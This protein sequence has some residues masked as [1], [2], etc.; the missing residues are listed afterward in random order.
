MLPLADSQGDNLDVGTLGLVGLPG[1]RTAESTPL[2][3]CPDRLNVTLRELLATRSNQLHSDFI[4]QISGESNVVLFSTAEAPRAV[5]DQVAAAWAAERAPAGDDARA[6]IALGNFFHADG[7]VDDDE[8]LA[9]GVA[10]QMGVTQECLAVVTAEFSDLLVYPGGLADLSVAS[11]TAW[12]RSVAQG[13]APVHRKSAPRPVGDCAV[14]CPA[15]RQVVTTSFA[16]LLLH[17]AAV[18]D[19]LVLVYVYAEWA[20]ACQDIGPH[21]AALAT[22]LAAHPGVLVAQLDADANWLD[23]AW[24]PSLPAWTQTVPT[25]TLLAPAGTAPP[26]AYHGEA[27]V[28][29]L[30]RF[31]QPLLSPPIDAE[32]MTAWETVRLEVVCCHVVCCLWPCCVCC[33]CCVCVF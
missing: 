20:P 21:V 10:A 31:L 14:G 13:Q 11:V 22:L 6:G 26:R 7:E 5:L 8:C 15:L 2:G 9:G 24:A 19:R 30:L 23:P 25:L 1:N 17:P 29:G 33:V 18:R 16:E 4:P 32:Q 27:T 3:A 28:R 12:L